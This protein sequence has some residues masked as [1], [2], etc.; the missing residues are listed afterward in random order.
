MRFFAPYRIEIAPVE[1]IY[2]KINSMFRNK[3][4]KAI[5]DFGKR[6]R[7]E[8]IFSFIMPIEQSSWISVW[9]RMIHEAEASLIKF[10][11][12]KSE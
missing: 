11:V 4:R 1:L 7:I 8:K 10:K 12:K 3:G 5:I 9:I 6:K 2:G